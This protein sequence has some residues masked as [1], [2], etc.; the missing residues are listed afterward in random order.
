MLRSHATPIPSVCA[1]RSFA[2]AI[3]ICAYATATTLTTASSLMRMTTYATARTSYRQCRGRST[4]YSSCN[5]KS[6]NGSSAQQAGCSQLL[7]R[8]RLGICLTHWTLDV[9]MSAVTNTTF[10][11]HV[12]SERMNRVRFG[13]AVLRLLLRLQLRITP[14]H[15]RTERCMSNVWGAVQAVADN[16]AFIFVDGNLCCV[17]VC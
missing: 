9:G 15:R 6:H 12:I 7:L 14:T 3:H 4:Q 10:T 1:D 5:T 8:R 11:F 2:P 17:S 13:R 16:V